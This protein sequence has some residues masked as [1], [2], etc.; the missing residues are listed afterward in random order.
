[1]D[2][3]YSLLLII[4]LV[5]LIGACSQPSDVVPTLAPVAAIPT[6]PPEA[7]AMPPTPE[8]IIT[9]T[10]A[11]TTPETTTEPLTAVPTPV[12][13]MINLSAPEEGIDVLMGA[14]IAARGLAQ[15]DPAVHSVV[16]ELVSPN[17]RVLTTSD[18]STNEMGWEANL[19]VP[20]FVSGVGLLQV[21]IRDEEGNVL[22]LDQTTITLVLD[23]AVTDRYLALYR[24]TVGETSVAGYNLFF[25]GRAQ[26]PVSNKVVISVWADNCQKQVAAQSF[27]LGGSGYW[28]GFIIVPQDAAGAACAVAHFGEPGEETWREAQIPIILYPADDP[29][30]KGIVVGN[31][32]P[33]SHISAGGEVRLYGTV[34]N[35]VNES[36]MISV[37]LD[38]GRIISEQ[39]AAPDYWGY[40]E[41][42]LNL[43]YDV[44]GPAQITVSTGDPNKDN[45]AETITTIIID[46]AL[47][48]TP[49]PT[50]TPIPTLTPTS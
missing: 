38:N 24:P 39:F 11:P 43:P 14:E 17:G 36:V 18:A 22:A 12:Q 25:D 3:I 35:A 26:R 23:T 28:Q 30:A 32:A 31:P 46:E 8:P 1:M 21:S 16:V 5:L 42:W 40:W 7:T 15:L 10:P 34:Y 33:N 9:D 6:L 29:D 2:R 45:Y 13:P 47:T 19:T 48:P 50:L 41:T 37:L 20:E 44:L 27:D 4:G 49:F